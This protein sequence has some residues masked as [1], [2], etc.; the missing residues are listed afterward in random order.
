MADN[1]KKFT[2]QAYDI[3]NE[4]IGKAYSDL[5]EKLKEKLEARE[6]ADIRR[7]KLNPESPEE[8]LLS[9][10]AIT[11]RYVFGYV[12]H[13]TCKRGSKYSRRTF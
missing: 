7:M 10:F 5:Q 6:I 9:D 11:E 8:D 1:K 12:A 3:E 13:I 4:E 2:L